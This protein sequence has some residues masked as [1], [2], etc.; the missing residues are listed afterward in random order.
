MRD[1]SSFCSQILQ[2][3]MV[4]LD[5]RF[6]IFG[7]LWTGDGKR[8]C[9]SVSDPHEHSERL[10]EN[11]RRLWI[12]IYANKPCPHIDQH[13]I[14]INVDLNELKELT[15]T[16]DTVLFAAFSFRHCQVRQLIVNGAR[17]ERLEIAAHFG[18]GFGVTTFGGMDSQGVISR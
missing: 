14:D 13:R 15:R 9:R 11:R 12:G 5:H 18:I 8:F 1:G 17:Q 2:K 3:P 6:F 16:P 7:R 10:E 4:R